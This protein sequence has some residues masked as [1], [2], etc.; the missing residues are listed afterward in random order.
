MARRNR[1]IRL[2]GALLVGAVMLL[3]AFRLMSGGCYYAAIRADTGEVK[4]CVLG[5]PYER[6]AGSDRLSAAL[7]WVGDL[8]PQV[9]EGWYIV[10]SDALEPERNLHYRWM[11]LYRKATAW[12]QVDLRVARW[13]LEDLSE[14]L[15][16]S[17]LELPSLAKA[18]LRDSSTGPIEL[19]EE[20]GS[21]E[22]RPGWQQDPDVRRYL[23][24]KGLFR[25]S[26][27]RPALADTPWADPGQSGLEKT[28]WTMLHW[29]ACVGQDEAV[30]Q[31]L[32][33]GVRVDEPNIAGYTPLHLAAQW[34]HAGIVR[35]LLHD[36]AKVNALGGAGWS[37]LALAMANGHEEVAGV[38]L[39][40]G[41]DRNQQDHRGRTPLHHVVSVSQVGLAELLLRSGAN[42]N[43][44]D[45]EGLTPLHVAV[46]RRDERMVELLLSW[47]ADASLKDQ[48]GNT[49]LSLA[50]DF[51]PGELVAKLT[52][53]GASHAGDHE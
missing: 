9:D 33:T 44:K 15:R 53:T 37:P 34:G 52:P 35:M 31:L 46:L 36:G 14:G 27:G 16:R 8:P 6:F 2:F 39:A 30:R 48:L 51:G 23:H 43:A 49:P 50:R 1:L 5:F 4:E 25:A 19:D 12:T 10:D 28:G 47:G 24:G 17:P 18:V 22:V 38:L 40:V 41:A 21:Y 20:S 45:H 42:A 11:G 7:E 26:A 13:V 3:L 32:H 29:Q